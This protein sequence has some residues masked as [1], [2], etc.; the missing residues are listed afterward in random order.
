MI[1]IFEKYFF[2][3]LLFQNFQTKSSK[4]N[5]PSSSNLRAPLAEPENSCTSIASMYHQIKQERPTSPLTRLR[6]RFLSRSER[7]GFSESNERQSR[8]SR[9]NEFESKNEKNRSRS[10]GKI[11]EKKNKKLVK[12]VHSV[13]VELEQGNSTDD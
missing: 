8:S 7:N 4:T 12:Q 5:L 9:R 13:D 6:K 3:S 2:K 1:N 11:V 10:S